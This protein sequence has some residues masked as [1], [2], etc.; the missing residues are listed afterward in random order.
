MKLLLD[1]H[2]LLWAIAATAKLSPQ[3]VAL[4][5]SPKNDLVFSVASLWEVA[6][7]SAAKNSA[8]MV[9]VQTMRQS[10]LNHHYQ[11]LPIQ[12]EHTLFVGQLPPLHRDPF[13]RMLIAQ[14]WVEGMTL[15]TAD[16]TILRYP[17]RMHHA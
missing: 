13:D 2:V 9:D 14:A 3:T 11:E 16:K 1:T 6:I 10:L 5:S 17:G 15:V 4:L 7:K 12:G 8:N